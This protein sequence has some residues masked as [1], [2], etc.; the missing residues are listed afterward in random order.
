MKQAQHRRRQHAKHRREVA[1][2]RKEDMM[3]AQP[4]V[5]LPPLSLKDL[6][7]IADEAQP[8]AYRVRAVAKTLAEAHRDTD[9]ELCFEAIESLLHPLV[10]WTSPLQE[11]L[12]RLERGSHPETKAQAA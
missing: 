12:G 2:A 11:E 4:H 6:S 7:E 3:L 10:D 5:P 1:R 8:Q 9:E